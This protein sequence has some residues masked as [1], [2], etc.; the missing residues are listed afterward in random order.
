MAKIILTEHVDGALSMHAE[1]R[2]IDQFSVAFSNMNP[3][4]DYNVLRSEDGTDLLTTRTNLDAVLAKNTEL[5]K[6]FDR[7][8][9]INPVAGRVKVSER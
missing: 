1:S 8:A 5:K 4:V 7:D 2:V 6:Q 3:P 9:E